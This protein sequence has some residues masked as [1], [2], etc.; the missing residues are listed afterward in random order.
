MYLLKLEDQ[1]FDH[2]SN[3]II[4]FE[5][6]NDC[7][8]GDYIW[9]KFT[10]PSN[11]SYTFRTTGATDTYAEF[12]DN[13]VSGTTTFGRLYYDNDSGL[14]ENFSKQI[15]MSN[16]ETIYLRVRGDNWIETGSFSIIVID[17]GGIGFDI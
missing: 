16:G 12:F 17:N 5:L 9:Y 1:Y 2:N 3:I 15:T 4:D 13:V 10:A 7:L 14:G 6:R 11:G 8:K